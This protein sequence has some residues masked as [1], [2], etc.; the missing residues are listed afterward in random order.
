MWVYRRDFQGEECRFWRHAIGSRR[1]VQG[2]RGKREGRERERG[3]GVP[4]KYEDS[5]SLFVWVR[6]QHHFSAVVESR[7]SRKT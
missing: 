4:D 6:V 5:S 1:G 7:L 2:S 3:K